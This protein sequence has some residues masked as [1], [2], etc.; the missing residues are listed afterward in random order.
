MYLITGGT[1]LIGTY[2]TRN[3][4]ARGEQVTLLDV[5]ADL[6]ALRLICG[7]DAIERVNVLTA[8]VSIA[9]EVMDA[10]SACRP[11]VVFHL[12]SLL[13]PDA[14]RN[15]VGSMA[16]I[17]GG[18]LAVLDACRIFGVKRLIWASATS[19]FGPPER[20]GGID[21]VVDDNAPHYPATLYGIT[22]STN[23]RLSLLYRERYGVDSIGFRFCQGYGPGKR[24]G[25]PFGYLMF[26]KALLK[27]PYRVPYGDDIINW[28]DVEDI[29]DILTRAID[30][31]YCGIPVY[32]TSGDVVPMW[33]SLEVLHELVPGAKIEAEPGTASLVWRY[34]VDALARDN[35]FSSPTP[36][37]VGFARTLDVLR[38]WQAQ[39]I[40]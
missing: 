22:K 26:E 32:N 33:R 24:R 7:P 6:A 37:S 40:W 9:A 3:L 5:R 11:Q 10:I 38:S 21:V 39:G 4:L 2:L 12:A 28:Q 23:E 27:E 15:A 18:H 36:I 34:A 8:D 30:M 19:V 20:H 17:T 16:A 29:A 35:G 14:E 31:R 1:G 25:R 13:P